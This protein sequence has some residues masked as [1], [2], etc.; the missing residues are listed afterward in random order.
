MISRVLR[1][2]SPRDSPDTITIVAG[3]DDTSADD[4]TELKWEFD[5]ERGRYYVSFPDEQ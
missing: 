2:L 5:E 4:A 1:L 3:A